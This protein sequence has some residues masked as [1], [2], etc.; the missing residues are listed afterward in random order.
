VLGPQRSHVAEMIALPEDDVLVA[1]MAKAAYLTC[2]W[3]AVAPAID[4]NWEHPT[5]DP[6][7]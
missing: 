4:R 5:E 6:S 3:G 2:D 1:A 7:P